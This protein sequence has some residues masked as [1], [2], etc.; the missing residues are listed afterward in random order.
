MIEIGSIPGNWL[1][2]ELPIGPGHAVSGE[3]LSEA[4]VAEDERAGSK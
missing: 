3:A 1:D 4:Q 2:S